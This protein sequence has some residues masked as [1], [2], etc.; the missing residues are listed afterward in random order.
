[1]TTQI[2]KTARNATAIA[3]ST[4][5]ARGIQFGWAILLAGKLGAD[6]FGL[7]GVISG[8]I[9]TAATL[10][11]F[12]MGLIVLRDVAQRPTQAGRYLTATFAIQP[13]LA[14]LAYIVLI[15]W[16]IL[17]NFEMT[18]RLLLVMGGLSLIIDTLGN[19]CYN[20]LIAVERMVTTSVILIIHILL[21]VSFAFA[22]L[23]SGG[24][25]PA[26][27]VAT[28]LAGTLRVAMFWVAMH[29]AGIKLEWPLDFT[30]VRKL[31]RDGTPIALSGFF[32]LA[33]QYVDRF[34]LIVF[35]GDTVLGHTQAAYLSAAF[36]IVFGVIEIVNT[37]VLTAI[38]PAMSRM[39]FE[40][41]SLRAVT[42]QIAFLTLVITLPIAIG[43]STLAAKV[44]EL[45]FPNLI[46]TAAV[47]QIL[48]WHSVVAMVGN[49][50]AQQML[51]ENKQTRM[52][53]IR[54]VSLVVSTCCNML[55]LPT[56]GVQGAG[57][58]A[59][60]SASVALIWF[61]LEH[62]MSMQEARMLGGRSLRVIAAGVIMAAC[63][64]FARNFNPILAGIFGSFAYL[65]SIV[66]LR[67][68]SPQEWMIIR[69]AL[70]SLPVIGPRL[71]Q[72]MSRLLD[73]AVLPSEIIS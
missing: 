32:G 17:F 6:G 19:M 13:L 47:L 38:F 69:N 60:I 31:F 27:Y 73:K 44:S 7:Y 40:M 3:L 10:P 14:I 63:I 46:G 15:L 9:A 58:A 70:G 50:Y 43:I 30:I 68:L 5:L 52:V 25:L 54:G 28:V 12:G 39:V 29:R 1:M 34:L 22:A 57:I 33:Y 21:L 42:D 20:Q 64:L 11:E 59:L 37:T 2:T 36:L 55:L 23:S 4:L 26:L 24:G 35:L 66:M 56:I 71:Q 16:G 53:I 8:L 18:T 65:G 51:I 41:S 61:L 62:H 48:I 45:L 72:S 67:V 49:I